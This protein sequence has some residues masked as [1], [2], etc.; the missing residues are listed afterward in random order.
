MYAVDHLLRSNILENN[1]K[2]WNIIFEKT[3]EQDRKDEKTRKGWKKRF[4]RRK[5]RNF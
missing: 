1:T 2:H 3:Y 4:V 5:T